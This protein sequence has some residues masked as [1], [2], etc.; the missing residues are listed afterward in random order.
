MQQL[1]L[2][3]DWDPKQAG[4]RVL[5]G[6]GPV[7][8][9]EVKGAHDADLALVRD[10]A[11][12]VAEVNDVRPGESPAWPEVYCA[13]SIVDLRTMAVERILPF[14]RS[15]QAYANETL[16][17]GACFVPRILQK[18]AHSLR[19]YFATQHPGRGQAQTWYIDLDLDSMTFEEQIGRAS[20]R[21]RV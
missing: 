12:I 21:E 10:L 2:P 13:L 20:C 8:A 16:P 3:N 5:A 14:A 11:Y 18:D 7:T 19:C 9:P 4:D 1:I 6:L 15:G 17:V